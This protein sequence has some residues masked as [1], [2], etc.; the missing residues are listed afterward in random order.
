MKCQTPNCEREP[1]Y[2][3]HAYCAE[4]FRTVLATGQPPKLPAK[5]EPA[6]LRYAREHS[7]A[8]DLTRAA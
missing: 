8:K 2:S 6:W 4:C 3:G 7:L 5:F 1:A